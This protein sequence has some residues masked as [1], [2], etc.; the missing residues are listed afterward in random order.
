MCRHWTHPLVGDHMDIH[1][2]SSQGQAFVLDHT[3]AC[4]WL[5]I[6]NKSVAPWNL[7]ISTMHLAVQMEM[8]SENNFKQDMKTESGM[9]SWKLPAFCQPKVLTGAIKD[10]VLFVNPKLNNC[11]NKQ[12]QKLLCS[13]TVIQ[14][15]YFSIHVITIHPGTVNKA[16]LL[17]YESMTENQSS[18][19]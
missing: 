19:I 16:S 10:N 6:L 12:G 13:F 2:H 17:I 4:L 15:L 9:Q 5:G 7:F 3:S 14:Y 11:R 8:S 1:Q 18:C